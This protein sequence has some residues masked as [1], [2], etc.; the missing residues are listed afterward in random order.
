MVAPPLCQEA[1]ERLVRAAMRYETQQAQRHALDR[2]RCR[3]D[4][5]VGVAE[6]NLG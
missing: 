4:T 6:L 3:L 2:V 1:A 5:Q